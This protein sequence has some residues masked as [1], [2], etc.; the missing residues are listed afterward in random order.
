MTQNDHEPDAGIES[1]H[2]MT[3][4][5]EAFAPSEEGAKT[6]CGFVA[7]IGAPNAGKS[8]LMNVLVGA[9]VSI[10]SRKVQ[11]TR[12]LVRGIA[13][14]GQRRRSSSSIRP[15]SFDPTRRLDRAMVTSSV[16]RRER[17][18]MP[19][20]FWSTRQRGVTGEVQSILAQSLATCVRPKSWCLNK[21]DLVPRDSA[22]R[23]RRRT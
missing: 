17:R 13:L 7:L 1:E 10:V 9:K 14:E 2:D 20:H 18:Q 22:A 21:I 5:D 4:E 3:S 19:S 16:G 12:A 23:A 6:R 8:T 15:A 11:T